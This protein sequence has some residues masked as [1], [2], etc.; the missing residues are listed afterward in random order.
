[1]YPEWDRVTH[2]H[3]I[4]ELWWRGVSPKLR[5]K[6]WMRAMGNP[7]GLTHKSYTRALQRAKDLNAK[8]V[9]GLNGNERKM[10]DWFSDIERDAKFAF[11]ELNLFQQRGPMW[12]ELVDVCCAYVSYR[13]DVGYLYGI[14]VSHFAIL[15]RC[16]PRSL[17]T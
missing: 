2:E 10:L 7:L 14:Q 5:G 13:S 3:R 8:T 11:P 17:L 1:V 6:I 9:E 16:F 12:Q 4:R 15:T